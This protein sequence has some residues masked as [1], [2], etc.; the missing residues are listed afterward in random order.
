MTVVLM[1]IGVLAAPVAEAHPELHPSMGHALD[2]HDAGLGIQVNSPEDL[3][4]FISAIQWG[5]TGKVDHQ[6]ADLVYAG[7]G[8]TPASYAAVADRIQG[9]I[10]IVDARVSATNPADQC[11]QYAFVQKVQS[12]ERAGAIGFIQIPGEGEQP[13]TSSTAV[14]ATI[15]ALE[16]ERTDT[17]LAIRDA[18]IAGT[19]VNVT[20]TPPPGFEA[21]SDVPC[22]DGWAGPFECDGIDLLSLFPAAD[23]NS[24]GISDLWGWTDP[25]TGDEYVIIGKTNGVAFFRITDPYDPDYLGEL[26]NQA[27]VQ[28]VWHDIKVHDNH[29]FIV[30]ESEPHGMTVFDLTRL[31]DVTEPQVWDQDAFYRLHSAAHNLEINTDTGFA[32]IVGGN[33]GLVVPDQCLS[34]LHMVD[35]NDPKNPRFA[36]CYLEEGGPGTAARTAGAPVS[37]AAYV[38]DA[39]CV[40]YD[41]PDTRYTGQEI[42]FNSAETQVVIADVT[43]KVLPTTL[44]TISYEDAGYTHQGWLTDD[45]R[46]LVVNDELDEL[47]AMDPETGEPGTNTRTIVLDVS[48][49]EAPKV[50]FEYFHDTVSP[51]HNNYIHEG[52]L[53]QSNYSSGLRVLDV[54]PM[55][56][57]DEPTLAP[58]AFFDTFP[59]HSDV[60][61]DG[62][63]SNYP[64]FESGTIAVSG[65]AEGLFLLRLQQQD[66]DEEGQA[67]VD[68]ECTNCPVGIRAGEDG[69]ADLVVSNTGDIDDTYDVTIDG[70]PDGWSATVEPDTVEVAAG[71]AEGVTVAV[72]V[73]RQAKAGTY[74][75]TVTATSTADPEVSD[76]VEI[77]VD[78]R[79]GKPSEPGPPPGD[80]GPGEA[81]DPRVQPAAVSSMTAPGSGIL[82]VV[83]LTL[84]L[85]AATR[86]RR[87]N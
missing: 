72:E 48:D 16:I 58:V 18:V 8:C 77:T 10:A 53:Y 31:R 4:Q 1:V 22:V 11:P 63:W 83:A 2:E 65:R 36:G 45:H 64:F 34:G 84:I 37:P 66:D 23:F 52:L 13:R 27:E 28:R 81:A 51:D 17:A 54:A 75:L 24:A 41:G 43:N 61:F 46:Y 6:T 50:H 56:D 35:I 44:G 30:S 25:D 26:P 68:I 15:P 19:A 49:L 59:R 39:N 9:A 21:M 79:K 87:S 60:T 70:L 57:P 42:C 74:S 7:T 3:A 38:H 40:I 55:Y 73:P 86:R 14:T 62:T 67:G 33:A 29:A 32:Y 85:G 76:T 78:V 20:F 69:S 71:D 47:N 82:V 5:D 80:R 12:A